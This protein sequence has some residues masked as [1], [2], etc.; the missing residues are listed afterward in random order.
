MPRARRRR[1]WANPELWVTC[2]LGPYNFEFM[3]AV[4]REIVTRYPVD[5]VF[6][7]RWAGHGQCWCEHCRTNFKSA[8]GLDLPRADDVSSRAR[9]EYVVWRRT[10][11]TE[12]WKTWNAAISAIRPEASFIPNGPPDM[13]TA[14]EMAPIQFADYQARRGLMPPWSNGRRAKEYRAVMG[15]RPIGGIFSVGLEEPYRWKDSVQSEAEIR[16]FVADGTAQGMRPWFTKFSGVVYDQR[17]LP[18]VERIYDWHYRHERYLRNTESLARVA[19]LVSEQTS[20]FYSAAPDRNAADHA[21]GMYHALVEARVPFDMVHEAL[22][23]PDRLDRYALLVLAN[24]AALSNAQCDAIR[25]YV[26]RGGSVLATFATSLHDEWGGRRANFGLADLFGVSFDGGIEGPLQ[27][28]YLSLDADPAT[29][30]RHPVLDGLDAAPR[31]INGA[32]RVKVKPTTAFPSPLDADSVVSRS[33]DG[34]CVSADPAHRHAR[35]LPARDRPGTR[36]LLPVGHRPHVLGGDV[37]R[38]R[39][40]CCAT[41]WP[42][43]RAARRR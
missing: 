36:R 15:M 32:W 24:A 9:R 41:P 12:L 11:L 26:E 28:S 10:R 21:T 31:I 3:T 37:R 1:H 18:T 42:G 14:S 17:W 30:G 4:H 35:A 2:A 16:L 38:S 7:N 19:M 22:L 5:A 43:R 8:T 25:A 29:G 34:G 13:K 40:V 27:N 23:T 6:G 33:A 39:H 20:T